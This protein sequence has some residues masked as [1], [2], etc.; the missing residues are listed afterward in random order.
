MTDSPDKDPLMTS[1]IKIL[2][3]DDDGPTRHA[4]RKAL[5]GVA[6]EFQEASSGFD[7]LS[8][9]LVHEFA[10]ILLDVRMPDMD[11]R[12]VCARL[13]SNPRTAKTPIILLTAALVAA[14]D[15]LSGYAEG[16]TD[17]LVKPISSQLLRAKVHVFVRLF[18]QQETLR[19]A[20][21]A[22]DRAKAEAE[23]ASLARSK[24]LM[25]VS[26]D[27]RQPVQS[28]VLAQAL[29]Q[30]RNDAPDLVTK[31]L[32]IMDSALTGLNG[33]LTG[34]IDISQVD[35][36]VVTPHMGVL[37]V[38]PLL[39][40]LSREYSLAASDKGLRLML[41]LGSTQHVR[42]DP[43]LLER[44]I[45]NLIENSLRYTARGGILLAAR[46]RSERLAVEVIDTGIGIPVQQQELI[47]EEFYRLGGSVGDRAQGLG[48][49]LSVVARLA[50][51][52]GAEVGVTSNVGRGSRFSILLPFDEVA[53]RAM[54]PQMR[55]RRCI[56]LIEDNAALRAGLLTMVEGW[57]YDVLAAE[58]GEDA[59][60]LGAE[61]AADID[62]ILTD[63]HLGLGQ[64]GAVVARRICERAR[65][66]IPTLIMTGD[67]DPARI[68][69]ARANGFEML[70]KPIGAEELR[71]KLASIV[72]GVTP[73]G[74]LGM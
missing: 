3:V 42:A 66:A 56:L 47:F 63:Y 29:L 16:A 55:E 34:V 10:L 14:E 13:R 35:A 5:N 40:R 28:L 31:A 70:H 74:S 24:F 37:D 39:S 52:I 60:D 64:T 49:G 33:L 46:R 44:M 65:R 15:A 58:T 68:S 12:E 32:E 38:A 7:A 67:T 25:A 48:L 26:H 23:R 45:R 9:A 8:R 73:G 19:G 50:R 4:I 43:V 20:I 6:V 69:D 41:F 57:G 71:R 59:L 62:A 17:Y 54:Y 2:I 11:G 21:E 61:A 51:L 36:G 72:K 18:V 22:A 27:L 53:R 1:T 30:R